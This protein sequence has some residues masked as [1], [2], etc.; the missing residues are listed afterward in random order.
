MA[1]SKYSVF[2]VFDQPIPYRKLLFYPVLMKDYFHFHYYSQVL[3]VDKNTENSDAIVMKDFEYLAIATNEQN[4]YL[5][6]FYQLMKVVLRRDDLKIDF[7]LDEKDK[8]PAFKI[9]DEVYTWEDF[10]EI[11]VLISEQNNLELPDLEISKELRDEMENQRKLRQKMSNN[12]MC[13]LE[14]LMVCVH[15]ATSISLNEIY[16]MTIRKFNKLVERTNELIDY[17]IYKTAATGGMVTFK[18]KNFPQHW[19]R[20]LETKDKFAGLAIGYEDAK[21]K[22]SADGKI[23]I[24]G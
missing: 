16:E 4:V 3:L 6:L 13:S 21:N 1:W 11:K 19:M 12:K 10:N 14:D 2:I 7:V 8:K 23:N 22:I 15:A 5:P 24:V 18:D 20:D 17:K 9:D